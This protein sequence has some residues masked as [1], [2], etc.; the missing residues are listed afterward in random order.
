MIM[1]KLT[2]REKEL[3]DFIQ[4]YQAKEGYSP[5][6]REIARGLNTKSISHVKAMVDHLQS[7]GLLKVKPKKV[8]TI[9]IVRDRIK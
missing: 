5:T 2:E 4:D 1:E 7:E 8:R 3:L 6:L 9:V